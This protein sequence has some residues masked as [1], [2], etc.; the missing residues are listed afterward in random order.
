MPVITSIC[1]F[2]MHS[3]FWCKCALS[4]RWCIDE[5]SKQ[6]LCGRI[7]IGKIVELGNIT[8]VA[9]GTLYPLA[10]GTV[11]TIDFQTA[12]DDQDSWHRL[13]CRWICRRSHLSRNQTLHTTGLTS[14]KLSKVGTRWPPVYR[15]MAVVA[16]K[17][18]F[19]T[20]FELAAGWEQ[21]QNCASIGVVISLRYRKCFLKRIPV[22]YINYSYKIFKR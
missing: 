16:Y 20:T 5:I 4:D 7:Y 11:I 18:L 14:P 12:V 21:T 2:A 9:R 1:W 8:Y 10:G 6:T 19:G 15:Y 13:L 3:L 22:K 17:Q